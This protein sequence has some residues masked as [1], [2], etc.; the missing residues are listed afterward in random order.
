MREWQ[1][2]RHTALNY[3]KECEMNS[4]AKN[5]ASRVASGELT[6]ITEFKGE[7]AWLSNFYWHYS[8]ECTVEHKFQAEKAGDQSRAQIQILLAK[9]PGEAKRLGQQVV[10]PDNW[11]TERDKAMERALYW[12]FS[13][14]PMRSWLIATYP[15]PLIEG[16][17]WHD[18]YWGDC[19]CNRCRHAPGINKVG[20]MLMRLRKFFIKESRHRDTAELV[21]QESEYRQGKGV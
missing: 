8:M 1:V 13:R 15:I 9:T 12:K 19:G 21:E 10:L 4:Y 20:K 7:F 18:N 11:D 14:E 16:N 5:I 6:E 2:D 17:Y 3:A